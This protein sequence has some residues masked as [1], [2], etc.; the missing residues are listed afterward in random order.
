MPPMKIFSLNELAAYCRVD[1]ANP[2]A[3][4]LV[5]T[6][7]QEKTFFEDLSH[8]IYDGFDF[9]PLQLKKSKKFFISEMI[10]SDFLHHIDI[11]GL[12]DTANKNTVFPQDGYT[13]FGCYGYQ[14]GWTI[15]EAARNKTIYRYYQRFLSSKKYQ[16][17]DSFLKTI[18]PHESLFRKYN[19]MQKYLRSLMLGVHHPL[20]PIS[21]K[22]A[23]IEALRVGLQPLAKLNKV[24]SFDGPLE[25]ILSSIDLISGIERDL[26]LTFDAYNKAVG[27][28]SRKVSDLLEVDDGFL[29]TLGVSMDQIFSIF[30]NDFALKRIKEHQQNMHLFG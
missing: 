15:S 14:R 5:H 27:D 25:G 9:D 18:A 7:S 16:S 28:Y 2:H 6:P 21:D 26:A 1:L 20:K 30:Q 13:I 12:S 4:S 24:K 23:E 11:P 29:E 19:E 3:N 8:K 10:H 17:L 22:K